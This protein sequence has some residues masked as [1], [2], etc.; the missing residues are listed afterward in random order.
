M[1]HDAGKRPALCTRGRDHAPSAGGVIGAPWSRHYVVSPPLHR[2]RQ[3]QG[4]KG[5]ASPLDRRLLRSVF[6]LHRGRTAGEA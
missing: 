5:E 1:R 6:P 3:R 4:W 2:E